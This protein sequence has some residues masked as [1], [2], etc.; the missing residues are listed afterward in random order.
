[1]KLIFSYLRRYWPAAAV[2]E[3]LDDVNVRMQETLSG[4]GFDY[5]HFGSAEHQIGYRR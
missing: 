5:P 3:R 4:P 1:M 2:Q